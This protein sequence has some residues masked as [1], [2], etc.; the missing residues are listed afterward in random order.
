M[1]N[2]RHISVHECQRCGLPE[3]FRSFPL[4]SHLKNLSSFLEDV[5]LQ[6]IDVA[7]IDTLTFYVGLFFIVEKTMITFVS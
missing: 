7:V 5:T 1:S 2:G 3:C 6:A 4:F